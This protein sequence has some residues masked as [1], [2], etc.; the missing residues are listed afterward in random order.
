MKYFIDTEFHEYHKRPNILG[1]KIGKPIPTIDLISIAIVRET[2]AN[3]YAIS[4][5]FDV[6]DAWYSYQLDEEGNKDY[7]LRDNVLHPIHIE[8][9]KQ[10]NKSFHNSLRNFKR[11]IKKYGKTKEEIAKEIKRF[12]AF[13][14]VLGIFGT[15]Y[16]LDNSD[17][18]YISRMETLLKN[19][20][21]YFP[22]FYGY[23]ADYDWVVLSQLY[24]KMI[25]LPK[26][27]PMYCRDLKQM[28]DETAENLDLDKVWF[29]DDLTED[30]YCFQNNKE[31][32][33][34]IKN[35]NDVTDVLGS[36]LV[37]MK[38]STD[39]KEILEG[40][41]NYPKQENVHLALEDARWNFKL[42]EFLKNVNYEN[43]H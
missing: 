21:Y 1:I 39:R 24:G 18:E 33:R 13:E 15:P 42:Y 5:E 19:M 16:V 8:L 22:E 41:Y 9:S 7:W 4:K 30:G 23:Y 2:G 40:F 31:K 26:Y 43:N 3:Y 27:F 17:M 12:I 37:T 6:E 29:F 20:D 28:F 34:C 32:E 35:L 14:D 11:L 25:N 38:I 36:K 10:D